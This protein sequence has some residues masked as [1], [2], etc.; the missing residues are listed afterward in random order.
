MAV[1]V[2]AVF[3]A[4]FPFVFTKML[5]ML[6]YAGLIVVPVG[7]IVFTEHVIFPRIGFTRYWVT[8]R[9][10][11]HSTP[12]VASWGAGLVLRGRPERLERDVVLL[13]VHSHLVLHGDPLHPS[14]QEVWSGE[15][16]REEKAAGESTGKIRKSKNTRHTRLKTRRNRLRITTTTD[17]D[18]A[19]GFP[20]Q[21]YHHPGTSK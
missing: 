6:T 5:P 1:G 3:V 14:R 21:P 17:E 7:A 4:C 20:V 11:T 9:K 10:L 13:P 2:I 15:K 16:Y 8:Y 19:L 12:A 18:A